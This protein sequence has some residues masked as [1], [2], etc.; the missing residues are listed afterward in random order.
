MLDACH[1]GLTTSRLNGKQD[2]CDYLSDG[3]P[4]SAT[5]SAS[6]LAI[7][8]FLPYSFELGMKKGKLLGKKRRVLALS[9]RTKVD[10]RCPGSME[11]RIY[12]LTRHFQAYKL[13]GRP[14]AKAL[15]KFSAV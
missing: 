1:A 9:P 13:V 8:Y 3:P 5:V 6:T 11:G 7:L 4:A 2:H 14:F 10:R 12:P 15:E